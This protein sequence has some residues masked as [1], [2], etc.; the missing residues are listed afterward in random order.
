MIIIG[1][2]GGLGNQMFQYACGK[3]IANKLAVELKLDISLVSDRTPTEN[4][5]L[6]EYELGVF[7]I[8][9]QLASLSEVRR[10]VPNLW[11]ATYFTKKLFKV[12]RILTNKEL[13]YE[14]AKFK[15]ENQINY[16]KD[17][18]YI[19]GYFQTDKYF[20]SIKTELLNIFSLRKEIDQLNISLISKMKN[21]NSVSIHIR[22][23]DYHCSTF[24]LLDIS[25][26]YSKAIEI[27]K[28]KVKNPV[29]YIFSNDTFWTEQH[30]SSF[31]IKKTF[32]KNN[33]GENSY[34]DMIL[35][36][37]CKHNICANSSFSWWGAWLNENQK[38]I[39]IVPKKWFKSGEFIDN[40][41]DL[42]PASWLQI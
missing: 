30:F 39:V 29:F 26:Y 17:N 16:I 34:M 1:I 24:E 38:R 42:I 15:Y 35:M 8:D 33:T 12:K 18:T 10:F 14:K 20:N 40:T 4:F 9:E 37:K 3:V 2:Y 28:D 5:T 22:R 32:V 19:H 6:R 31:D 7:K 23:G 11:N 36:S 25:T 21:E 41:Y 27:I 13:Y